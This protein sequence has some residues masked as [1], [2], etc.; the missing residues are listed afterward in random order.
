MRILIWGL[1]YVGTVS[2]ACFAELGHEVIGVEPNQAK[3]DAI[4]R[5]HAAIKEPSLHELVSKAVKDGRLRATAN[6]QDLVAQ[7]KEF[8]SASRV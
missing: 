8:Q 5:G 2:A 7:N 6:G 1:G 4:N 3:V